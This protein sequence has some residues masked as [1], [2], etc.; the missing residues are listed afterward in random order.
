MFS[1]CLAKR[2]TPYWSVLYDRAQEIVDSQ[3]PCALV[4]DENGKSIRGAIS[5][6]FLQWGETN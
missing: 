3:A 1:L 6:E 5:S 2:T 4:F